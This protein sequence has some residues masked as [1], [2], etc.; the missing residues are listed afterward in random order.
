MRQESV[1][2]GNIHR[3]HPR[4]IYKKREKGQQELQ[5]FSEIVTNVLLFL[6]MVTYTPFRIITPFSYNEPTVFYLN[7]IVR[8]ERLCDHFSNQ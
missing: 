5:R 8:K 1:I 6:K 4:F 2:G 3:V 7:I